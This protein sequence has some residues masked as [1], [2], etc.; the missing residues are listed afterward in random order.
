MMRSSS[1]EDSMIFLSSTSRLSCSCS[2][3][4]T[5]AIVFPF[6]FAQLSSSIVSFAQTQRGQ[7]IG[8][9]AQT[10]LQGIMASSSNE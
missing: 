6:F 10:I 4:G 3:T 7:S 1:T 2:S 8:G 9:A 5:I